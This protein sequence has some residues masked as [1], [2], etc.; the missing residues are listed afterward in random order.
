[1]AFNIGEVAD[2]G[3]V[4]AS[5][6]SSEQGVY[7]VVWKNWS[8]DMFGQYNLHNEAKDVPNYVR[9]QD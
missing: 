5:H 6:G 3:V 1:M 7:T 4:L 2:Y 8:T 9:Q